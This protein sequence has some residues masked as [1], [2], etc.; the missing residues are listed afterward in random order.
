MKEE[1]THSK[2]LLDKVSKALRA[3]KNSISRAITYT[4]IR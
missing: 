3:A 4:V 1:R 2:T